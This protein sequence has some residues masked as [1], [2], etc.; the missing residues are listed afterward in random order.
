MAIVDSKAW[1]TDLARRTQHYGFRFDYDTLVADTTGETGETG[2]GEADTAAPSTIPPELDFGR[3]ERCALARAGTRTGAEEATRASVG[4]KDTNVDGAAEARPHQAAAASTSPVHRHGYNQLTVNEY[5]PGMGIASHCETHS[6]FEEGFCSISL[7]AGTV[8]RFDRPTPDGKPG[9]QTVAIWLPRRS[10][11]TFTGDV[12][13]VW[14]HGIPK[15]KTD[16]V[17]GV[18][19]QR[20]KRVSLTYRTVKAVRGCACPDPVLC[21][22]QNPACVQLPTGRLNRAKPSWW[23]EPKKKKAPN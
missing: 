18:V 2:G 1:C 4:D 21:D 7:L 3:F 16:L 15:R 11:A 22:V 20:Q 12:R 6:C 13:Y 5:Y 9:A 17:D 10:R 23:C 8:M 19:I 14:R